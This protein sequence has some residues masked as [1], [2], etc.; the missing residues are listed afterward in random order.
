MKAQEWQ[1]VLSGLESLREVLGQVQQRL[2]EVESE[3][4]QVLSRLP[5][6]EETLELA[7]IHR[8][9]GRL[10]TARTQEEIL[11]ALLR[12][13]EA[14]QNRAVLFLEKHHQ[15]TPWKSLGFEP[16]TLESVVAENP[17]DPVVRAGRQK[18]L[19]YRKNDV[20]GAF[21]WSRQAD[22]Q[23][24]FA[25]CVPILFGDYAPVVLYVDSERPIPV[26]T[27]ELFSQ[28]A[29]LVIKNHY[30]LQLLEEPSPQ[31]KAVPPLE[32]SREPWPAEEPAETLPVE[33][34]PAKEPSPLD[35][36]PRAAA[37]GPAGQKEDGE[38]AAV[39]GSEERK[40]PRGEEAAEVPSPLSREEEEKLHNDARRFARLLIS[41]IKLYHEEE[42]EAGRQKGDLYSRLKGDIDR[43]REMYEKRVHPLVSGRIDYF[44]QELVRILA[45]EEESLLG[46]EYPGPRLGAASTTA[47][48]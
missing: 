18:T 3:V 44:H 33:E 48:G 12:E 40:E 38:A 9:L 41:E 6:P 43:S 1:G 5:A 28:L 30:L 14:Q 4:Q 31:Q 15:Y 46:S 23:P 37:P 25:A 17:E 32:V 10:A 36:E 26:D 42:V 8:F 2:E 35:Q 19:I 39:E 34:E 47:D 27:W 20:P 24:C 21:P 45:G 13:V 11:E 16:E 22:H 7:G 29:A